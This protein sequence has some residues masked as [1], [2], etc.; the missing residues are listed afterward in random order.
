LINEGF[1]LPASQKFRYIFRLLQV[2]DN[3]N[4]QYQN[5]E[6]GKID[7]SNSSKKREVA[8]GKI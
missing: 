5:N 8:N 6:Y 1:I 7:F 3:E 4:F 2:I